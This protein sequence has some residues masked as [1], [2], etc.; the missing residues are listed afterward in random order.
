MAENRCSNCQAPVSGPGSSCSVCGAPAGRDTGAETILVP[1]ARA[2]AGA[3]P[4]GA[5]ELIR[6]GELPRS[7]VM[8]KVKGFLSQEGLPPGDADFRLRSGATIVGREQGA[9]R[10]GDAAVSARHFEVEE[11]GSE[12][13]VRDLQSSNGTFLNGHRV[14]SAKLETGDRI[15]AGG[16]TFTFSVRR[17][18]PM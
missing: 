4:G 6:E 2:A 3:T 11:R 8:V 14:R 15:T 16:T 18:I 17:I 9:I 13:F 1:E 5:T 12:F 7:P 10:L